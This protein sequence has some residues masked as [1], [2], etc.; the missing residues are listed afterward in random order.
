MIFLLE[1]ENIVSSKP[2]GNY[3]RNKAASKTI[4][5]CLYALGNSALLN[6]LD[7]RI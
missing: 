1:D 2:I 7:D 5:L 6:T 4:H 3:T